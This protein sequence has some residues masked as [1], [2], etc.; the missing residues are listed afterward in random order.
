[1]TQPEPPDVVAAGAVVTRK[2]PDGPREVLLVHR[3]RYDDWSFPKGKVDAGEHLLATAVREVAEETGLDVR[4][5]PSLGVLRYPVGN[6]A[7]R[8]K[9]V[10]YWVGRPTGGDDLDGFRANAEVD[11]LAW[12][13]LAEAAARLTYP[14]DAELLD[15]FRPGRKTSWPLVVLRHGRALPRDAWSGDDRDRPLSSAGEYQAEQL[16]PLLA[17]YGITRVLS[18]SSRRCWA[19]VAPYAESA[20]VEI[21]LTDDL[22]EE[23]AGGTAVAAWVGELLRQREPTA[24]CTHRPVLPLVLAALGLG[25]RTLERGGMLVAH[26][27]RGRVVAV[28][29]HVAPFR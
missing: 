17:A 11:A 13:S 7:R 12:V 5:G 24:L 2:P 10:H 1:M 25:E 14:H 29:E 28:E 9:Q 19:T 3:P 26:H 18:S 6:G 8:T 22:T 23:D 21:E 20:D 16:A 4:L 15:R 27:R